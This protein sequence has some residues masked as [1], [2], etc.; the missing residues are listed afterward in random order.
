[1]HRLLA[2]LLIALPVSASADSAVLN[3]G[4][5]FD[6]ESARMLGPH[7]IVVRDGRIAELR[8]GRIEADAAGAP[9]EDSSAGGHAWIDLG[10]HT[11]LPGLI[12]MHVHLSSQTSPQA[13]VEG[14]RLNPEDHAFRSVGYAERTLLAGFTTVR[15]LG[16]TL[17]PSLRNAIDAGL[18]RG[19]RI[20]AAGKSLATTGGH[21]DPLNGVSREILHAFG[22]PGPEDGVISGPLE[23]RRAVRQRY[24]DGSDVIKLTAT[25]GVLSFARSGD[26]PQF[27]QDEIAAVV[28]TA[29]DYG[30]RVAAHAHGKEGMRR[31][32][33]AG[34]DSIEHGTYMDDEI[35][36]LMKE[37]GTWY[38]PTILAGVFVSEMSQVPGYYPDVVRPKAERIGQLIQGTFARAHRAGVKIA[39]GTDAGVYPHGDNG[40]EFALMVEAGMAPAVALQSATR[41]AAE[42]LGRSDDVGSIAVGK[43]ADIVA[44]A[45]D[46]IADITLM[47]RVGFVMKGGAVVKHERR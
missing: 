37:H 29:R 10:Q 19:P 6:A 1:M 34:V 3:C 2:V 14:F 17:A 38:V 31:A 21:A 8:A 15:D 22:Y 40:R 43:H 25:G 28:A 35:F 30:Y 32:V 26:N 42:L 7:A 47:Q 11:C 5:L 13:Y 4:R 20:V 41:N 33:I 9:G 39:F 46:P 24:K 12:D 45:G 44:V 23:A 36:A 27:M 16:G 18:V